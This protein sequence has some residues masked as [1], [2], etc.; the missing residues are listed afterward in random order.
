MSTALP[1]RLWNIREV[2]E[3][4]SVPVASVYKMTCAT[5]RLRIPHVKISGKLRFRRRDVDEWLE[6][7]TV[8]NVDVLRK[9]A[10]SARRNHGVDPPEETA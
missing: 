1:D 9:V 10:R 2:A 4:L 6:L 3:Y 5:A 7:L 8:S